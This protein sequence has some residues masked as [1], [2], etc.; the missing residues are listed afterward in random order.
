[1]S[2]ACKAGEESPVPASRT[3]ARV[4]TAASGPTSKTVARGRDLRARKTVESPD[5]ENSGE[6]SLNKVNFQALMY[7]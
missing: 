7:W 3:A 6:C 4:K 1:M 5:G 2:Y